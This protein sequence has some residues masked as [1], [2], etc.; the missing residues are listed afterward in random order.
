VMGAAAFVMAEYTGISYNR[1]ALAAI[2]PAILYYAGIWFSVHFQ[3]LKMGLKGLPKEQIPKVGDVLRR[4]WHLTIPLITITYLLVAG[5]TPLFAAFWSIVATVAVSFLR[6]ESR[7]TLPVLLKALES[8]ARDALSVG[9]ACAAVG[10]II[11]VVNLTSLGVKLAANIIS[12]AHGVS[13]LIGT[14][15]GGVLIMTMIFSMAALLF[16]GMGMPT[17][18][19][20]IVAATIIGPAFKKL[21]VPDLPAHFFIFYYA[22][23]AAITPPVALAAFAAAGIAGEG[24]TPSNVGWTAMKL[25]AAGF[26]VPY[27]FILNP[28]MLLVNVTPGGLI[29]IIIASVIGAMALGASIQ[30]YWS[31]ELTWYERLLLFISAVLLIDPGLLTDGIGLVGVALV[32]GLQKFRAMRRAQEEGALLGG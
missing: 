2:L 9:I 25:A 26:L 23:T 15:Q 19:E 29:T 24:S 21:G 16:L 11:G 1:I 8:G 13:G 14:G 6:K 10:V 7:I 31:T 30:G 12:V 20:Y 17:T 28:Q 32:F 27:I 22:I 3:A 4:G 5:K 18:V